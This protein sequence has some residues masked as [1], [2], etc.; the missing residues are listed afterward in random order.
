[1][2][3]SNR[4]VEETKTLALAYDWLYDRW[5][6]VQRA[7]LLEKTLDACDYEIDFI[8]KEK[9]SPYNVILYNALL[10]GL[11]T[12]AIA[13]Y[14][15]H[16][17]AKPIM[18]FTYDLWKNRV[19]PAW[20]QIMGKNGGWHEGGEYVGIGIGQAIY[21][22]PALWRHATGEDIFRSVPGIAGFLDFLIYRTLPNGMHMRW[23]DGAFF[24][25]T[26]PD[27][28][29]LAIEFRHAAAYT[30]LGP[31][32]TQGPTAWP[33]GPLP[34]ATLADAGAVQ[35]LPLARHFDG[36]GAV[37][38][39]S[40][41]TPNAT[42]VSFRAGD[43]YWSHVHLDQGAFTIYKGG[44]LAIDSGLY[45]PR[46][47]SDHHMNY[48]YQTIAHNTLAVTDPQDNVPAPGTQP[49]PIANEGGQRRIGSGWG[50]EAAP[51]DFHEWREKRETYHTATMEKYFHEDGLTIAVADITPAYTNAQ[52]GRR[53]FSHRTRRVER[54]WR[55]FA[56]DHTGD[57]VVV[58]DNV[59]STKAH[60]KKKW[61][62]HSVEQPS[63]AS[64]NFFI[65]A[66][67][68][69]EHAGGSLKG[70]VLL[71]RQATLE[72]VGG[73]GREFFVDGRN[74]DE[75]GALQEQIKRLTPRNK[76]P[77]AWRLEVS[78]RKRNTDD[79]FLVVM[80]PAL[81]GSNVSHEVRLIERDKQWG[82]EIR[83][84][85]RTT[86]WWYSP[87]SNGVRVEI[88]DVRG[89]R[90]HEVQGISEAGQG[91][92][93]WLRGLGVRIGIPGR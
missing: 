24:D 7:A 31:P 66:P 2:R 65:E 74:Y 34:D 42:H 27:A 16:E 69:G 70:W 11:M 50:V 19:L 73:P 13:V 47:G 45:G 23:G 57:I 90:S 80:A 46:S 83:G 54:F 21:Q 5:S 41:W 1:L 32:K 35:R 72:A 33:W 87:H 92:T 93:G 38:A 86:R 58:F 64:T 60:F 59:S 22:V 76:H 91:F 18:A 39:R 81:K 89:E 55:V 4:G 9:L 40:D 25:R 30:Q 82:A 20:Q 36:I 52:S 49:R 75:G 78:P 3:V 62:L 71:P 79:L 84:P 12:C 10:Q 67:A 63:V 26:A 48:A 43:N 37:I 29:A 61:L 88:S 8:R 51:M 15:D 6:P 77:G 85:R 14:P 17:R 44:E 68:Q 53:T 28:I 56:Y